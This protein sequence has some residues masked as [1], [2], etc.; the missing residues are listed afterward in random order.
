MQTKIL[1]CAKP[2]IASPQH[3]V[4]SEETHRPDFSCCRIRRT[5]DDVPI[6]NEN[7]I[8]DHIDAST[9]AN[10]PISL[11]WWG[12]LE[13][14]CD[15]RV[16]RFCNYLELGELSVHGGPAFGGHLPQSRVARIITCNEVAVA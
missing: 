2:F 1:P 8:I 7:W 16:E 13:S 5:G 15:P 10:Q 9:G 3:K 14:V 12:K 11:A 4:L 6:V